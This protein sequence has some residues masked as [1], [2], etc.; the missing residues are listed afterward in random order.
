MMIQDQKYPEGEREEHKASTIKLKGQDRAFLKKTT[1]RKPNKHPTKKT[2]A[3]PNHPTQKKK[4]KKK[5]PKK[6]NKQSTRPT[7][8]PKKKHT[9][10][11]FVE[12]GGYSATEYE[13][14]GGGEWGEV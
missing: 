2:T 5:Q 13:I 14:F 4:K 10:T 7:N 9:P 6:T 8:Q 1:N 3:T 11:Q 12:D